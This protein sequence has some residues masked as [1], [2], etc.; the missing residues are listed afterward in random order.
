[1][2]NSDTP[3]RIQQVTVAPKRFRTKERKRERRDRFHDLLSLM[4]F[5]TQAESF[6]SG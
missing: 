1:M 3:P 2:L 5:L 6:E 4:G